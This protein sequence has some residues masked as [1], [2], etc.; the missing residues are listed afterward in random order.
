LVFGAFA[1]AAGM[2]APVAEWQD[3][4]QV[5]WEQQSPIWVVSVYYLFALIIVPLGAVGCAAYIC[6]WWSSLSNSRLEVATRFVYAL[7]PLGFAMWLSH[8]SFHLLTSYDVAIPATQRFAGDLG[9]NLGTPD[10]VYACCRPVM[11]WL[12]RLEILALDLG[13]LLS[14]YTAYRIARGCSADMPRALKALTPWAVVIVLL[15]A[16]GVWIVLQPMQM[17]GTMVVAR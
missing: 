11:N 3:W 12:P 7:V 15:F 1:N 17:R 2:V 14:L 6:R 8:Y 9:G 16:V 4:L 13:L 5:H 10:W